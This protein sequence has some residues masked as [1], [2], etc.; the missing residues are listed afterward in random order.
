M[1]VLGLS[2]HSFK[3]G[4]QH[5]FKVFGDDLQ[6]SVV[7]DMV[8]TVPPHLEW[9]NISTVGHSQNHVEIKATLVQRQ[10]A[11]VR[12][13]VGDLTVTVTDTVTNQQATGTYTVT[14]TPA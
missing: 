9:Q 3:I 12:D 11:S 1:P 14:Y 10:S 8:T 5:N 7:T 4:Q 6:N 2:K 13:A